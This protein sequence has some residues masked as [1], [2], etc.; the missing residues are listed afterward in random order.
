MKYCT[1]HYRSRGQS[2]CRFHCISHIG[3]G[4]SL[5]VG[6]TVPVI[7]CQGVSFII[8]F[9]VLVIIGQ[10]VSFITGFNVLVI[11]CQGVSVIIISLK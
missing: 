4:V 7:I 1:S 3:Q 5:I 8:G 2:H 10:G 9:I 6:F 11:I